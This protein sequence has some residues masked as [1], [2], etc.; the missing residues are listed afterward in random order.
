M[1]A[2]RLLR[3]ALLAESQL[4][5]RFDGEVRCDRRGLGGEGAVAV[6]MIR[7][8]SWAGEDGGRVRP[9]EEDVKGDSEET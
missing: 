3:L 5:I 4:P 2:I 9:V 6:A 7:G 1:R 8:R